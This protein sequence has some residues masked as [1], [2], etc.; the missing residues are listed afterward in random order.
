MTRYDPNRA[1]DAADWLRLDEAQRRRLVEAHHRSR[2]CEHPPTPDPTLHAL[3]HVTVE[4]Q[5]AL[6]EST[7]VAAA[8]ERLCAEGLARHQ[9]VH[10]VGACLADHLF[11]T[12]HADHADLAAAPP[13][14]T[15]YYDA[16]R[17]LTAASWLAVSA[18]PAEDDAA[19][20]AACLSADTDVDV[21]E[22]D[23]DAFDEDDD[24][25]DDDEFDDEGGDDEDFDDS[26]A[27]SDDEL[28]PEDLAAMG[29]EEL[30]ALL[31]V[32]EDRVTRA[33]VDEI[34][35]RRERLLG[36]LVGLSISPAHW[37]AP[38]PGWWAPV[39]A[40]FILAAIDAPAVDAVLLAAGREA[41]ALGNEWILEPLPAMLATRGPR[42]HATLIHIAHNAAE[43]MALRRI[44]FD[45][46]AEAAQRD[47]GDRAALLPILRAALDDGAQ[48]VEARTA[49]AHA[50]IDVRDEDRREALAAFGRDVLVP[51]R[52]Q[53]GFVEFDD[54]GV[55]REFAAPRSP[56]RPPADWLTFYEPAAIAAR[57][58]RWAEEDAD[59]EDVAEDDLL[60]SE[61]AE[62]ETPRPPL[63]LGAKV[64]RNDPCPCGSGGKYKKCCGA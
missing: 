19:F 11:N 64:G 43:P 62:S 3:V 7:P 10:A 32:E 34:V 37:R 22:D 6:G 16:V 39:H 12:F 28:T 60:E 31:S 40:T 44:M 15:A 35:A 26:D 46:L 61:A 1:L 52:A 45:A 54:E 14:F 48:D 9:A 2:H 8:V 27:L 63:Q 36:S 38:L 25:L 17:A 13:D 24:E 42:L 23:D 21:D 51:L 4:D 41:L 20:A 56:P 50:L 55:H 18:E 47:A 5:V 30:V 29:D 49:A 53:L 33:V 57:Q 58:A 59:D